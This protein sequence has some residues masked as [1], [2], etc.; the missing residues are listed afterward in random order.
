M[1]AVAI[2]DGDWEEQVVVELDSALNRWR[3]EVPEHRAS[4]PPC[5][6]R[7]Y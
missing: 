6:I 5:L 3:D 7:S 4:C 2:D 1:F